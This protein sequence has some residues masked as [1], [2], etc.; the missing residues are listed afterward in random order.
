MN[1]DTYRKIVGHVGTSSR[2]S[3]DTT[4]TYELR[5]AVRE[6]LEV[7]RQVDPPAPEPE[8]KTRSPKSPMATV[9]DQGWNKALTAILNDFGGDVSLDLHQK[10]YGLR[11]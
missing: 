8:V 10:I 4:A 3:D 2:S 7:V 9:H 1:S 6:L 5:L 11:K